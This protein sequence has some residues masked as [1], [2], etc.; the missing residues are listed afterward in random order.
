[1]YICKK[2]H[3][4]FDISIDIALLAQFFDEPRQG[5]LFVSSKYK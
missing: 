1:M 2:Q 3:G 5:I 4:Y